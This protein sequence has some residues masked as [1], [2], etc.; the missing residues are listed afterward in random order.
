VPK[1]NVVR[2]NIVYLCAAPKIDSEVAAFGTVA[3]NVVSERFPGYGELP[4]SKIGVRGR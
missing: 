4:L 1:Y 3:E 2:R